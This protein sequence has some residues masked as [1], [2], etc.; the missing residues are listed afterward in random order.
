MKNFISS[1]CKFF[2]SG[3]ISK[4]RYQWYHRLGILFLVV[5]FLITGLQPVLSKSLASLELAN[6][7]QLMQEGKHY[8]EISNFSK[9]EELLQ[10]AVKDLVSHP[11][12]QIN[13]AIIYSDLA[14]T[15]QQLGNLELSQKYIKD[16]FNILNSQKNISN[17]KI[18][19]ILAQ[20][21]NIQGR[22]QLVQ[23]NPEAALKSFNTSV[24]IYEKLSNADS[25]YG[26]IASK[27][28]QIQALQALGLFQPAKNKIEQISKNLDAI[29]DSKLQSKILLILGDILRSVGELKASE[30]DLKRS[31]EL[32]KTSQ[33]KSIS[34]LSLG[35]TFLAQAILERDRASTTNYEY[36][37]WN[38]ENKPLSDE[39]IKNYKLA[40]TSYQSILDQSSLSTTEIKA[41]LNYLHLLI[42]LQEWTVAEKLATEINF[43]DFKNTRTGVYGQINLAKSLACI[44]QKTSN[45]QDYTKIIQTL[46]VVIQDAEKLK[47]NRA[48]SYALGNLAGLY[49]YLAI[50]NQETANT[51]SQK[52]LKIAEQLTYNALFFTQPIVASDIAYQWEWQLA[53]I[54]KRQNKREEAIK[55][56]QTAITTLQSVRG[57]L[58]SINSDVQFSFRDNVEPVYRELIDLL[59]SKNESDI[60]Q[61]DLKI[62]IQQIN[63][64]Q[65]AELQNFL[66]CQLNLE[67]VNINQVVDKEDP[68]AAIFYPLILSDRLEVILKLPNQEKLIHY[69]SNIKQLD[70]ENILEQLRSHLTNRYS[71][72]DE[73]EPLSS[74]IYNLLIKPAEQYLAKKPIKTL[75]FVLDGSLKNIPISSL[76][77]AE[78]QKYLI[79]KYRIASTPGLQLLGPKR[80]EKRQLKA[81]IAGLTEKG[82]V[83]IEGRNFEFKPLTFVRKEVDNIKDILPESKPLV[84]NDF[85]NKNLLKQIQS[86]SYPILH[87]ATHGNFSS[88]PQETFILTAANNYLNLNELKN[89]VKVGKKKQTDAIEL[90]VFS[91]C[92]TATGDKRAALGMAGVAVQAGAGSTIATLWS[93]FDESTSVLMKQFYQHFKQNFQLGEA[94]KAESLR[95]AQLYLLDS[96]NYQHPYYWSPFIL[97]GNWL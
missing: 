83:K 67:P 28:N 29:P 48:K 53:R 47:D 21:L 43:D 39:A 82:E 16:S 17:Y 15:Y 75:V 38:C 70:L 33:D 79:Q 88:N 81:L 78:N 55:V 2:Q 86:S 51:Q 8:Y 68:T 93:V 1:I 62:A 63:N 32:A 44:Q 71:G 30:N 59:L 20:T 41:K 35:N 40:K 22:L 92:E 91:A 56:Y 77:D 76:W 7:A 46:Q 14:L 34:Q 65:L 25:Q 37:P 24:D 73:Y 13:L 96:D 89:L 52:W 11:E 12:Q 66:Q 94:S 72:R 50:I 74:Q 90:M 27:I 5:V 45:S 80:L 31:W 85:D 49:E 42:E 84:D 60:N 57:D 19:E 69:H 36:I 18:S 4:I 54:Y 6:V 64:L 10:K 87:L 23:G 97:I 58:L 61:K 3:I 26:L 95:Q 9:A